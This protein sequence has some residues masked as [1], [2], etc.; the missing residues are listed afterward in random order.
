MLSNVEYFFVVITAVASRKRP[1]NPKNLFLLCTTFKCSP[2]NPLLLCYTA[3]TFILNE[4]EINK[5]LF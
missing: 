2:E 1:I 4:Q 3:I 5:C